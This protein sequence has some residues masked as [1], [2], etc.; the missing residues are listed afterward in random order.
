MLLKAA[1]NGARAPGEHPGL[2]IQPKELAAAGAAAVAAGAGALHLH[3]RTPAGE[4]SLAA[5]PLADTLRAVRAACPGVPVGISTGA[6]IEPDT[7]RR[8]AAVRSWQ[9]APD[10]ASVNFQEI[11]ATSIARALLE[12]G[13]GVEAGLDTPDAADILIASGL[14]DRCLRVLLEP[15]EADVAAAQATV[16]LIETRLD[17][18]GLPIRRL[19]HGTGLTAWPLLEVA[20]DRGYD[21]RIGLE[22]TL[23]LPDGRP[24]ADNAEL[25]GTAMALLRP[26]RDPA[27]V[28]RTLPR[29][30][31]GGQDPSLRSG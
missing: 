5:G 9:E 2:P 26:D 30:I 23:L 27:R 12:R 3:V 13:I 18:V 28:W 6:W 16:S 8:L 19:L 31:A 4:E 11:G 24:A 21:T 22:D 1:L 10:F 14:G 17:G 15:Q 20:R 29:P 7:E 25:V